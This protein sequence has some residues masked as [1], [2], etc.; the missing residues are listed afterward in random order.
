[1]LVFVFCLLAGA[2]LFELLKLIERRN[3]EDSI[4]I[5]VSFSAYLL[6]VYLAATEVSH[7]VA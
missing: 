4:P 7:V 3:Y 6:H 5:G 1:M 2:H